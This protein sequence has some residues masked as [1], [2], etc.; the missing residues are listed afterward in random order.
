MSKIVVSTIQE[1]SK[2]VHF[3]MNDSINCYQ[4]CL[5]LLTQ[6]FSRNLMPGDLSGNK[7]PPGYKFSDEEL[8]CL[9]LKDLKA[10]GHKGVFY[11]KEPS[12]QK[13]EFIIAVMNCKDD[14]HFLR[15]V[16]ENWYQKIV[17]EQFASS[18]DYL[19]QKIV[20]PS[21]GVFGYP[22]HLVGYIVVNK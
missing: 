7:R 22:Y 5:G 9:A 3:C 19:D 12:V 17:D 13:G 21:K 14:F 11:E 10:I 2:K 15:K 16:D 6:E 8:K 1:V 20:H 18:Y 4:F